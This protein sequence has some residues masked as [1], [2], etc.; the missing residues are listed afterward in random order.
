MTTALY[1][2]LTNLPL[3]DLRRY[4]LS[5]IAWGIGTFTAYPTLTRWYFSKLD[6]NRLGE[7]VRRTR[8]R[9]RRLDYWL[10]GGNANDWG[11]GIML[12]SLGA[13]VGVLVVPSLKTNPLVLAMCGALVVSGW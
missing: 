8:P 3:D 9:F 5:Y 2:W 13:V 10:S 1:E 12:L 6:H 11:S 4:L 7:V